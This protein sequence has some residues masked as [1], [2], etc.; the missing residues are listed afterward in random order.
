MRF[1]VR[2]VRPERRNAWAHLTPMLSTSAPCSER[3]RAPTT[4]MS[5]HQYDNTSPRK[6]VLTESDVTG[7]GSR[8]VDPCL[9]REI[10]RILGR[11]PCFS[12]RKGSCINTP[13]KLETVLVLRVRVGDARNPTKPNKQRGQPYGQNT[14][15]TYKCLWLLDFCHR[16]SRECGPT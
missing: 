15:P 3:C 14:P 8:F 4:S 11:L 2:T 10:G 9:V 6:A 12:S 7:A 1:C 5:G 16:G 13:N